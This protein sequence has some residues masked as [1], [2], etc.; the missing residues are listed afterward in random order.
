VLLQHIHTRI[1]TWKTSSKWFK[2]VKWTIFNHAQ[3]YFWATKIAKKTKKWD[4][5]C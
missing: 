5:Y 3:K 4:H 1:T 2:K